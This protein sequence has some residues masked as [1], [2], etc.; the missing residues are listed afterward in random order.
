MHAIWK[1]LDEKCIPDKIIPPSPTHS[2][3]GIRI[4]PDGDL[5]VDDGAGF[6]PQHA[7]NGNDADDIW[8]SSN[9]NNNGDDGIWI[10]S[11]IAGEDGGGW[12][13]VGK[14][15]NGNDPG[16]WNQDG[17]GT[18][19]IKG[20]EELEEHGAWGS[21]SK[22]KGTS[23]NAWDNKSKE[24]TQGGWEDGSAGAGN[25]GGW[26]DE[27]D[28]S[29]EGRSRPN[30]NDSNDGVKS[31]EIN[32]HSGQNSSKDLGGWESSNHGGGNSSTWGSDPVQETGVGGWSSV[33][34]EIAGGEAWDSLTESQ[35]VRATHNASEHT[36]H[37]GGRG[38]GR[39]GYGPTRSTS[40]SDSNVIPPGVQRQ[41]GTFR[42]VP[43]T[44]IDSGLP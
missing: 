10:N 2:L 7:P 26:G 21:S 12:G 6:S 25:E 42:A 28:E 11:P 5:D 40:I 44:A 23:G 27:G 38:R 33:S 32:I 43:K 4:L 35:T 31:K 37:N 41:V 8:G 15:S 39:G 20:Q 1:D 13:D 17:L 16:G 9:Q 19:G 3:P 24:D 36:A 34:T 14:A 18:D 22:E 30:G 29:D